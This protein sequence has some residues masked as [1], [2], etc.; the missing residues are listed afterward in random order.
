MQKSVARGRKRKGPLYEA[1][2]LLKPPRGEE[3]QSQSSVTGMKIILLQDVP[4]FGKRGEIKEARGGY[5]RNFLFPQKLAT[6]AT[7]KAIFEL[8]QKSTA[9][10]KQTQERT[11][12]YEA[13]KELL[14]KTIVT[15]AIK[16]GEKGKAFG[17]VNAAKIHDAL[18][19]HGIEIK[20]EW[21][22]LSEPI[23]ASGEH[24]IEIRFPYGVE[25]KAT[26]LV[27]PEK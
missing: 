14:A 8:S 22:V 12:R 15:I 3:L 24:K 10:E 13:L 23:K 21:M 1:W 18:S 4:R 26:I 11:A 6:P 25:G 16:V 19:K 20:K 9:E 27:E 5:A 7:E 17:S 2:A